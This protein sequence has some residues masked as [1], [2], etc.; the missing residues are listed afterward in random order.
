M[1]FDPTSLLGF[2]SRLKYVIDIFTTNA[3]SY[4]ILD[5]PRL[6]IKNIP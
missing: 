1:Y 3:I 5:N 4:C 6:F 2:L